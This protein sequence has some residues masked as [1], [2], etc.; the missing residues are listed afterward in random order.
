VVAGVTG[1]SESS[2]QRRDGSDRTGLKQ[3]GG[4]SLGVGE[5]H[6]GGVEDEK[7]RALDV[8]RDDA[9]DV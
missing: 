7:E 5:E 8:R 6:G 3:G 2:A 9:V 1:D 4:E